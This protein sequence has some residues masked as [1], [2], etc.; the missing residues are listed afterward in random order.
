MNYDHKSGRMFQQSKHHQRMKTVTGIIRQGN[1]KDRET[2]SQQEV[3]IM[4]IDED[5]DSNN[6]PYN[7]I[8]F[9]FKSI[10]LLEIQNGFSSP[11]C[12]ILESENASNNSN[13]NSIILIV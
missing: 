9:T 12:E 7:S 5:T 2:Y 8:D 11:Q 1:I 13:L 4:S 10:C 3:K 6:V